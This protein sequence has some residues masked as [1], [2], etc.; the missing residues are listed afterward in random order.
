VQQTATGNWW[1][2]AAGPNK[3][4]ADTVDG[5]VLASGH[6]T[7]TIVGCLFFGYLPLVQN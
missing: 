3:P 7:A 1:G 6:L 5:N 2:A 4:G